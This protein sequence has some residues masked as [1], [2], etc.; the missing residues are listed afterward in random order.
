MSAAL[1]STKS[2]SHKTCIG[3]YTESLRHINTAVSLRNKGANTN[4]HFNNEMGETC[5]TQAYWQLFLTKA[6][7]SHLKTLIWHKEELLWGGIK[8]Y[9]HAR[10]LLYLRHNPFPVTTKLTSGRLYYIHY[11]AEL[12]SSLET[13]I[14]VSQYPFCHLRQPSYKFEAHI[15]VRDIWSKRCRP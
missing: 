13:T 3:A 2:N 4:R 7:L 8:Q 15:Q 1:V 12:S 10:N 14:V 6:Q 11:K 5:S 9:A